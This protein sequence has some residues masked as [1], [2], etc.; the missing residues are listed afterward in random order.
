[1]EVHAV[2]WR[3]SGT[4]WSSM[5]V[6]GISMKFH[7]PSMEFH[8]PFMEHRSSTDTPWSSMG[9]FYTYIK[10]AF[11]FVCLIVSESVCLSLFACL[12]TSLFVVFFFLEIESFACLSLF[13]C[14]I[15]LTAK[16]AFFVGA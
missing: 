5:K 9:L 4:P 8:G 10:S 16:H 14:G 1:M 2:P 3:F 7:K 6:H 11:S 15:K 12:F 13:L